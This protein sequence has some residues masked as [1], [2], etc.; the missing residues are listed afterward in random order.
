MNKSG[1]LEFYDSSILQA[2]KTLT[3]KKSFI[4]ENEIFR[5]RE[6][7]KKNFFTRNNIH[8]KNQWKFEFYIFTA[9]A[10]DG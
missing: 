8:P 9:K 10:M 2:I 3:T 1:I 5:D 4:T 7:T 6:C